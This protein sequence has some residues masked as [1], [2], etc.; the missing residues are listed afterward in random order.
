MPKTLHSVRQKR[1]IEVLIKARKNA[2]LTQT[3][4][5]AALKR[6]QP[7]IA[8]IESGQRR[9]DVVEFLDLAEILGFD[10][11]DVIQELQRLPGAR[12]AKR[13]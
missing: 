2:D 12:T 3:Q 11:R 6:H 8:T 1:R 7:F 13:R 9:I 5:A 4:V 10:A